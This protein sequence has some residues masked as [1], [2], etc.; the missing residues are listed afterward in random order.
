MLLLYLG[1]DTTVVSKEFYKKIP[2]TNNV[3]VCSDKISLSPF[4]QI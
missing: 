2:K 3:N 1:P 4:V